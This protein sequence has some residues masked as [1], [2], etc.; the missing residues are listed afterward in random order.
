M[1]SMISWVNFKLNRKLLIFV[2]YLK[3][4][5]IKTLKQN[6]HDLFIYLKNTGQC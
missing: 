2:T 1:F 3:R 6:K 4:Q 5:L